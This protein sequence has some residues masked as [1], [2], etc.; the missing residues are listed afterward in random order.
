[1]KTEKIFPLTYLVSRAIIKEKNEG[2]DSIW[3]YH[4]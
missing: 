4:R 1:M 2:T 3:I